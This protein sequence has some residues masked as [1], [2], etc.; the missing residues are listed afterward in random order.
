[1]QRE[2]RAIGSR[3]RMLIFRTDNAA[4]APVVYAASV[5]IEEHVKTEEINVA[6]LSAVHFCVL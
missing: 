3:Y 4:V 2:K 6:Q 1:M 5:Y